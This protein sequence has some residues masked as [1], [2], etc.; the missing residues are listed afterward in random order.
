MTALVSSPAQHIPRAVAPLPGF[1]E[2]H[3]SLAAFYAAD[4]RRWPSAEVDLGLRWHG[5]GV[6]TYRAAFVE[7]TGELY[8]FEHVRADGGGGLVLVHERH[9]AERDVATAFAGW[10]DVCGAERSLDW[11]ICRAGRRP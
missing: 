3:S 6:S 8:V 4:A 9:F 11:L 7:D 10:R 5:A 2:T 1:R